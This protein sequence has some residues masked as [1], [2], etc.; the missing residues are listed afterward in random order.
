AARFKEFLDETDVGG[1][2]SIDLTVLT[3]AVRRPPA[4]PAAP[5]SRDPVGVAELFRQ[6]FAAARDFRSRAQKSQRRLAVTALGAAAVVVALVG[7]AV[8]L[9]LNHNAFTSS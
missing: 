8:G 1:F 4:A 2:G 3:T 5:P 6:V 9:F 7:G